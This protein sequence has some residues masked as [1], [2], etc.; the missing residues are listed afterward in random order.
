MGAEVET[1]VGH[2]PTVA[3]HE[4]EGGSVSFRIACV[5]GVSLTLILQNPNHQ[6]SSNATR[7]LTKTHT[8]ELQVGG[9]HTS[10]V[11]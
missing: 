6:R 11:L 3:Y 9:M 7:H 10:F 2:S 4:E 1:N 5:D 8:A